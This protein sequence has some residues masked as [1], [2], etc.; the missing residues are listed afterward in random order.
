MWV[1]PSGEERKLV[2]SEGCEYFIGRLPSKVIRSAR[3]REEVTP[4]DV[5]IYDPKTSTIVN[6]LGIK[7][8][9]VSR[10]HLRVIVKEGKLFI[11]DHG[12]EGKG[13][14]N[15][16]FVNGEKI[17]PATLYELRPQESVVTVRLGLSTKITFGIM[18]EEKV[19]FVLPLNTPVELPTKVFEVAK[20]LGVASD[21]VESVGGVHVT[22]A[23]GRPGR[24]VSKDYEIEVSDRG[25]RYSL[26]RGLYR[27][28]MYI[29]D[30]MEG[31]NKNDEEV[32]RRSVTELEYV[33]EGIKS[34]ILSKVKIP[35]VE[36]LLSELRKVIE[37]L[38]AGIPP[39]HVAEALRDI[40][41]SIRSLIDNIDIL[42]THY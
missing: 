8:L 15:G 26:E 18:K 16:T 11:M 40:R 33:V 23:T 30:F 2:L 9:T 41:N 6:T 32:I 4:F 17:P 34:K 20:N 24:Y 35:K 37:L 5:V 38:S 25:V 12:V 39:T 21:S 42:L 31:I 36:D 22:T 14:T 29:N 13:S 1:T 28:I 3:S 7:D 19:V 10:F 27:I